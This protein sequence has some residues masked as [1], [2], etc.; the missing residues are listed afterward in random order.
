MNEAGARHGGLSAQGARL[1]PTTGPLL[2]HVRHMRAEELVPGHEER[3]REIEPA[4]AQ[5]VVHVVVRRV[6]PEEEME[7]VAGRQPEAAVV[8]HAL[9]G[10]E[11]E[12]EDGRARRHA[13]DD[14]GQRPAERV[15]QQALHGV[16]VL[17][18]ERVGHDETVVPR[19][20]VPVKEP[21]QVHVPVPRVLPPV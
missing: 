17:R 12:E 16:V 3:L 14:E 9:G 19:V 20:D 15:E 1:E 18:A 7:Q 2:Q 10:A 11:R 4:A 5:L 13:G 6:V 21:V 8:V